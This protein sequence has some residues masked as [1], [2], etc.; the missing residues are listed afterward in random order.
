[1]RHLTKNT[2]D[3]LPFRYPDQTEQLHIANV[4]DK[5]DLLLHSC[6]NVLE[7]L[8]SLIK[9]RF[10]EMFGDYNLAPQKREWASISS[11]GI[12]VGGAT[13]KT[14]VDAYW[15]GNAVWITPAELKDGNVFV[16]D[17]ARKLTP[18][19]IK[20]A[21]LTLMPR[22][23]VIL[24]SRAPIGKVAIAN[25]DLYCNQGF[26]NIICGDTLA[27]RYLYELL[28][29]NSDFLNSLGKGATFKE[30]SKKTVEEVRI[31]IP[32]ISS[33]QE[34]EIFVSQVDKL[35]FDVQQQIERLET[36]KKSLMQEYFG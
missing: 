12:V 19:G 32:P 7:K 13:P 11:V 29:F 9:S 33:Q 24:S 30:I 27:P 16:D 25:C 17:S 5:V 14:K 10:I 36:L 1:M 3:S 22:N 18:E 21:S 4:L 26:K 2:F 23:T 35:R 6:S 20:S 15:G 8:D 31:P 28:R 34:Y